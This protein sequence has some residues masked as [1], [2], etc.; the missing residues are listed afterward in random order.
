MF[1]VFIYI[2]CTQC[3]YV[4]WFMFHLCTLNIIFSQPPEVHI[5]ANST[6]K[7][8]CMSSRLCTPKIS[9][10]SIASFNSITLER[11]SPVTSQRESLPLWQQPQALHC[12]HGSVAWHWVCCILT[13]LFLFI[14]PFKYWL[15]ICGRWFHRSHSSSWFIT[16]HTHHRVVSGISKS[17]PFYRVRGRSLSTVINLSFPAT[18]SPVRLTVAFY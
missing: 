10:L 14:S 17:S 16:S 4:H 5:K 1:N 9:I 8:R 7:E 18:C 2:L 12:R 3:M 15:D 11:H 6:V 13:I